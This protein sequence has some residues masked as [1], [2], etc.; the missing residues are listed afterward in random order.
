[1]SVLSQ[2]F[3]R[4]RGI[5]IKVQT[6]VLRD[7]A[8]FFFRNNVLK[9]HGSKQWLSMYRINLVCKVIEKNTRWFLRT[10]YYQPK[11]EEPPGI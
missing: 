11:V 8:T 10:L 7:K 6:N 3:Q 5:L 2:Q 9:V 1:M 4:S